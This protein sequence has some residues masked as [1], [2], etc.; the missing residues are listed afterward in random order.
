MKMREAIDSLIN[1]AQ[2]EKVRFLLAGGL[3]T[4][5]AYGLFALGLW[6]LTPLFAPLAQLPPA[7]CMG[8]SIDFLWVDDMTPYLVWIGEHS[9]LLIQW[10]MWVLSVPFGAFTLKY[11]AFRAEGAY[12][13]QALRAY[14][15]YLPAQLIASG[16]LAFFTLVLG[17]HPLLGQLFAL[18]IAI[19]VSYLGHKYFTFRTSTSL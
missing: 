15:V 18:T 2:G 5:L 3:N 13:P 19:I 16:L 8:T 7:E 17:F 14:V 9:Y 6:L 11:F 10:I 1:G 12:L 4:L